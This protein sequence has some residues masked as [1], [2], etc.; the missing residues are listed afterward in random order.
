MGNYDSNDKLGDVK[1]DG[2]MFCKKYVICRTK[3]MRE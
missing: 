1:H 2:V 3:Y